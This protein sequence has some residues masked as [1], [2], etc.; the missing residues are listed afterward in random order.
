MKLCQ[1]KL[2]Q[3]VQSC[4][5]QILRQTP[6]LPHRTGTLLTLPRCSQSIF[7]EIDSWIF[8]S[9][10]ANMAAAQGKNP[11]HLSFSPP[12]VFSA[13]GAWPSGPAVRDGKGAKPGTVMVC[14]CMKGTRGRGVW[15]ERERL[16][17]ILTERAPEWKVLQSSFICRLNEEICRKL[18]SSNADRDAL[19]QNS[20][21][22]PDIS[23]RMTCYPLIINPHKLLLFVKWNPLD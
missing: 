21:S 2:S 23:C 22:S 3:C 16:F 5:K 4:F 7:L 20:Q 11:H 12:S 10:V 6:P 9:R 8:H 19:I 18:A 13:I 1:V 15:G 17:P 14:W